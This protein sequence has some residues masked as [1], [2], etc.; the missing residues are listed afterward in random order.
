MEIRPSPARNLKRHLYEI[1]Y[2]LSKAQDGPAR[3]DRCSL[4]VRDMQPCS[5]CTSYIERPI[6]LADVYSLCISVAQECRAIEGLQPIH[7]G[8]QVKL[9]CCGIE[10]RRSAGRHNPDVCHMIYIC[11]S[12]LMKRRDRFPISKR[13]LLRFDMH[14]QEANERKRCGYPPHIIPGHTMQNAVSL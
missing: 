10:R 4:Y 5:V 11:T 14:Q 12:Y 1:A 9:F 8:I 2:A 7:I 6:V 13:N 3:I